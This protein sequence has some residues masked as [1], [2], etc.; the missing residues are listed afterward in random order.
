MKS[1]EC[2][3][4]RDSVAS[5]GMAETQYARAVGY[6]MLEGRRREEVSSE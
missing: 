3:L 4:V 6:E 2:D 5:L 1:Y